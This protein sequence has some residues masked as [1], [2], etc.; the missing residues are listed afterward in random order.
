MNSCIK[1]RWNPRW[2]EVDGSGTCQTYAFP[3]Q[4]RLHGQLIKTFRIIERVIIQG[5]ISAVL[6]SGVRNSLTLKQ[7][8]PMQNISYISY[9]PGMAQ[10]LNNSVRTPS[11]IPTDQYPKISN[12]IPNTIYTIFMITATVHQFLL[13]LFL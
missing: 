6:Y 13:F 11:I 7:S 9:H 5:T 12:N 3:W 1:T 4:L 8:D 10:F 2:H